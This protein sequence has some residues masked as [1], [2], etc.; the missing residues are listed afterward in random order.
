M[1][2][3]CE[4]R[5]FRMSGAGTREKME[6]TIKRT[7]T[8]SF[9]YFGMMICDAYIG[10]LFIYLSNYLSMDFT[11]NTIIIIQ[12]I[13]EIAGDQLHAVYKKAYVEQLKEL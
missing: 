1:K 6:E 10:R 5:G 11:Q 2:A 12:A 13:I 4:Q 3:L 9:I 7:R 8:Q